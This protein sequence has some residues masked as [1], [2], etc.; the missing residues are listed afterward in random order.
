MSISQGTRFLE[1]QQFFNGQRLFASDLQGLE[2]F[3]REMR[4]LH[5]QSLHQPG[6]GIGY[7]VTGAAGASEVT[8]APGYA[9]DALGREIVLVEPAVEP[10]PPV[11]HDGF[12]QPVYYDLTVSYPADSELEE[13]ETRD[14]I[15]LPRGVVRLEE[16]PVFCWIRL[17]PP[18]ELQPVDDT[19]KREIASGIRIRLAR[20]EVFN[21]VLKSALSVAQRR[22]A[23]PTTQPYVTCGHQSLQGAAIEPQDDGDRFFLRL[24]VDTSSGGFRTEPCYFVSVAGPRVFPAGA[25]SFLVDGITSVSIPQARPLSRFDLQFLGFVFPIGGPG[26]GIEIAIEAIREAWRVDWIGVEG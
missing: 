5:N 4:W 17:G 19:L 2:E 12:G 16:R 25:G 8:I 9:I 7:A 13:S 1:R 18:P 24:T 10:V 15:C 14:G 6:I 23:R 11:A 22:N 20:A 3:H 26:V 21:C